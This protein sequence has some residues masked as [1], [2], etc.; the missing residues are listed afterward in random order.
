MAIFHHTIQI[1]SRSKGRPAVAAAAYRAGEKIKN[2][3]DGVTHDYT[4]KGG[5]VH[6]EILL[7]EYAPREYADRAVLWNAV[8]HIEKAKNSQLAREIEIALPVELTKEQNIALACDYVQRNFVAHGMCADLCLHD[9]GDGNPHAHVML[10]MRPINEDMTWGDKQRKVYILDDNGNKIYDPKKKTYKCSKIQTTDWDERTKAEEWRES[11]AVAVNAALEKSGHSQRVDHRSYERQG[12]EQVPTI[13]IGVAA[14]QMERKGI[15][16]ERGDIN[17]E[18]EITNQQIRAL[19]AR[20]NKVNE[21]LYSVPIN[22]IAPTMVQMATGIAGGDNL[23][24]QWQ[25]IRDLKAMASVLVF[26]QENGIRDIGDLADTVKRIHK[27][28]YEVADKLKKTNRR[29]DTL[30]LHLAHH[31]NL[32]EHKSV[33]Q[34]YRQLDPKKRDAYYKKHEDAIEKYKAAKQ[35]LDAVMNGITP[36]PVKEWRKEALDLLAEK[37]RLYDEFYKLRGDVKNVETLRRSAERIMREVARDRAAVME[38][39]FSL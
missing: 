26:C 11:W 18:I 34:T 23:K 31:D 32:K 7:P 1:I 37:H 24:T 28:Q 6:T 20:I 14:M 21:W 27:Q 29:F 2:E 22:D 36:I 16:T 13:H 19:R 17:R 4:R 15:R 9:K 12:V 3:R 30:A 5:I 39:D 38:R 8:E 25:K 10:T 33:Y 35:Y